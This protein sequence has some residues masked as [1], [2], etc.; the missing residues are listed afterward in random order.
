[1]AKK[2]GWE[3][4]ARAFLVNLCEISIV[5]SVIKWKELNVPNSRCPVIWPDPSLSL[6]LSRIE[7]MT[8]RNSKDL[9][10]KS[11]IWTDV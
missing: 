10:F 9:E 11:S 4:C 7:Q 2:G 6:S 8:L 5:S 3:I 1:M